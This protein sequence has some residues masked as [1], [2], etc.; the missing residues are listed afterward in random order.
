[1]KSPSE[2]KVLFISPLRGPTGGIAT[3]TRRIF[4]EGL[5]KGYRVGLVDIGIQNEARAREVSRWAGEGSRTSRIIT[6]LIWHLMHFRPHI[7]HLNCSL[8]RV[9]IFRDLACALLAHLWRTPIL[10]HY[11]RNIPDFVGGRKNGI[12]WWPLRTLVRI[13][14]LNIA[15]NQ[16]SLACLAALQ[17]VKQ[18][19]P[20]LLPCFLQDSVFR[21]S[22]VRNTLP[23]GRA[24]VLYAGRITVAKGC[25]EILTVA[26][27]LP[28]ADFLL[29]G[30]VMADMEC[31]LRMIPA[32]VTLGG[33]LTVDMVLQRMRSSDIFLFPTLYPEGFPSAVVEAMAIGLPVVATRGCGIPDII[34]EGNGG[35][36][37]NRSD[38][39]GLISALQVLLTDPKKRL[40]MGLF[41]RSKSQREYAYSVVIARLVS[42]Y[43]QL[44]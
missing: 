39:D 29:L 33:D 10:V 7:V 6:S 25:R 23:T 43:R 13:S 40:Q 14:A 1:M 21:P 4:E 26:R 32:N 19:A 35:L 2:T 22:A 42:L 34:E 38:T 36:L 8:S 44:L 27:Q 41:N 12:S 3:W 28:E 16:D 37:V 5:P 11:H 15:L 17:H 9:G 31:H 18:P 20:V 24:K 30:P